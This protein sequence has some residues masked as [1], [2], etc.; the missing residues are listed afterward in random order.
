[1]KKFSTDN[2]IKLIKLLTRIERGT[3]TEEDIRKLY[4]VKPGFSVGITGMPGSGK[5]SVINSLLP[6]YRKENCRTGV[7]AFDPISPLTGGSILGDRVRMM[8]FATDDNIF[9]RSFTLGIML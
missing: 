9:I 2:R 4:S 5:S 8:K 1:M 6:L 3:L 7:L